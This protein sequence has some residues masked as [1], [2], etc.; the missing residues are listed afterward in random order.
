VHV[1]QPPGDGRTATLILFAVIA[2]A[3]LAY[4]VLLYRPPQTRVLLAIVGASLIAAL[5]VPWLFSADAFAYAYYGDLLVHGITPYAH[6]ASAIDDSLARS[7]IGAWNGHIPPRCVYGPLAVAL[8]ALGDILGNLAG[9]DGAILAQR[10][11]AIG[12]FAACCA[13]FVRLVQSPRARV[14]LLANP[15]IIWS[16][17]E[18]HNDAAMLALCLAAFVWPGRAAWSIALGTLVKAPALLLL[19]S[20]KC[21]RTIALTLGA[22]AIGY[23]PLWIALATAAPER[24]GTPTDWESPL[25]LLAAGIGR[26]PALVCAA[27]ALGLTI[28]LTRAQPLAERAA[29]LAFITWNILPNAYPWYSL[30]IVPIAALRLRSPWAG[31]LIVASLTSP[32]RAAIDAMF[33]NGAALHA[34]MIA[35]QYLPA[36]AVRLGSSLRR[37]A[38][39]AAVAALS[40]GLAPASGRAQTTPAPTA[41]PQ[42]VQNQATPQPAPT[43][44]L[45]PQPTTAPSPVLSPAPNPY[46]YVITPAPNTPAPGDGPQILEVAL[47]DRTIH[48]GGPLLA[49]IRTSPNVVGVEARALGRFIAIPQASPGIFALQYQMP[50]IPWFMLGRNYDVVIAAATADGRQTTLTVPM[51]IAR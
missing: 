51:T 31:A 21:N 6:S 43:A 13:L 44:T 23:L 9:P 25:G 50:G 36:L 29:A 14:A 18:G 41:L 17:A 33:P 22:I 42:P 46:T 24:P 35:L 4:A 19:A 39:L 26:V 10:V 27:G 38:L 47:N 2:L 37:P 15:V 7:A 34:E 5:C 1:I 45:T 16:V 11:V 8:A 12:A 32:I 49:R 40:L 20:I 30:W 3:T 28:W 48:S